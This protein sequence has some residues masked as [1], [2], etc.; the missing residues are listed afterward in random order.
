MKPVTKEW[1]EKA[2]GDFVIASMAMRKRTDRKRV[3]DSVCY[4]CQQCAE[5]Y[6]KGRL[7]E[8][9]TAFPY[10]HDLERILQLA[11]VHEPLWSALQPAGKFLTDCAVD[12]RYPG[13][14]ATE[15]AAKEAMRHCKA[16]RTEVRHSLRLK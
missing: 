1:V 10:T 5:K 8:A 2:E 14:N 7:V 3:L 13:Q 9:G 6:L 16:I 12:F 4:H 11:L 15:T